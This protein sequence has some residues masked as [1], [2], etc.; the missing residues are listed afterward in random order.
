MSPERDS[1]IV[2]APIAR[3]VADSDGGAWFVITPK[4]HAWLF[5]D[6]LAAIREKKCLDAQW[7]P[8]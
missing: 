7:W 1:N 5:G 2:T 3:I 4:G 8:R 6:R